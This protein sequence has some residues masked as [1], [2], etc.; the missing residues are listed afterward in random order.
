MGQAGKSF[1]GLCSE[2]LEE[3]LCIRD[4]ML[5]AGVLVSLVGRCIPKSGIEGRLDRPW[6]GDE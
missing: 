4:V 1:G 3:G 5:F 6:F 2:G